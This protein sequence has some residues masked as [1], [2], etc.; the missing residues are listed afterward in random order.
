MPPSPARLRSLVALAAASLAQSAAR[1]QGVLSDEAAERI[2]GEGWSGFADLAFLGHALLDLTLAAVLGAAI[3]YH[4]QSRKRADTVEEAEAPKS[5][6]T[7]AVVGAVIGLMVVEYGLVV[8][9][10]VFG[11]GG[12]FRFRT[13]L[14]SATGTGRLIPVTL[15]G[16]ACGLRLPH[17][18]VLATAFG[19]ALIFWLDR[20]IIYQL[21]VGGLAAGRVAEASTAYRALVEAEGGRVLREKR[22]FGKGQVDLIFQAPYHFDRET[23]EAAFEAGLP[24]GLRGVEN[25]EAN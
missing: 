14:P 16:L 9:F 11:I 25:W 2:D 1:A 20:A 18:G 5:Y 13:A 15:I 12:L 7:Y 3:A 22:S 19:F 6:L 8:G 21:S 10:V 23:L 4:P 24:E 17:L